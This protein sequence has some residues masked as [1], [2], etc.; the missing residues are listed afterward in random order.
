MRTDMALP[1]ITMREPMTICTAS[2]GPKL[3]R[4]RCTIL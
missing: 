2:T 1:K 3:V 4:L